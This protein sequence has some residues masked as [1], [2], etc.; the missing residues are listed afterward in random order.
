MSWAIIGER[1]EKLRNKHNLSRGQFGKMIGISAQHL[2]LVEKGT[3][4]LSVNSI[5]SLC[6]EMDV[7]ADYILFGND[8]IESL[9]LGELG[10]LSSEQIEIILDIIKKIVQF[11]NS[12]DGNEM[13][14]Q[15]LLRQRQ[16]STAQG[17]ANILPKTRIT[18]KRFRV[19]N[20]RML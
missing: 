5:V 15:E 11:A 4:G 17:V 18:G 16:S 1:I 2:G 8:L 3:R 19:A 10:E 13:L 12:E 6:T 9:S 20:S 7:S 14:I